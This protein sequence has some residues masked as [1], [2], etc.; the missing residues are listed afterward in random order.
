MVFSGLYSKAVSVTDFMYLWAVKVEMF[1]TAVKGWN[2][3][4]KIIFKI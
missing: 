4:L 1:L 3:R 2:R